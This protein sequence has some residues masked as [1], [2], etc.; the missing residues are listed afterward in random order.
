MGDHWFVLGAVEALH[1]EENVT[2]AM[3][4]FRGKVCGVRTP[5]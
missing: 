5:E 1:C 2:D 4:F 3:T